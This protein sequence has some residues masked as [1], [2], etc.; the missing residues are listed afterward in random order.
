MI[1]SFRALPLRPSLGLT[2]ALAAAASL[3][4]AT[5]VATLAQNT[6]MTGEWV[7]SV[8][9]DNGSGTR[10]VSI[11]QEGDSL[12]GTITSSRA[13]GPISGWIDG[14]TV[15]IVAEIMMQSGTPFTVYYTATRTGETLD[16]DVDLGDYGT[17]TFTGRRVENDGGGSARPGTV[18]IPLHEFVDPL[19]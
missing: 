3:A 12:S 18:A 10:Q 8:E 5:P 14:N 19:G 17:G 2:A 16:G 7:F 6:S 13:T 11:V 15:T 4:L 1:S 9:L